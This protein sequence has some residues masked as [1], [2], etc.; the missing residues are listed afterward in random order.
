MFFLK[1]SKSVAI[2]AT[3]LAIGAGAYGLA[4]ATVRAASGTAATLPI[5]ALSGHRLSR[6][7]GSNARSGPAAGGSVGRVSSVSESGFELLTSAGE[8]VTIKETPSTTYEKD[9]HAAS[10]NAVTKDKTALVLGVANGTTITAM[11]VILEPANIGSGAASKVIP[12]RRGAPSTSKQLGK[13]PANYKQGSGT[14]VSGTKAN[15]ATKATLTDYPGGIVDRVVRISNGEYEVHNIG[16]S[17]PH[18]VFV[19]WNFKVVGAD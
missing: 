3:A 1:P 18:H 12:F 5:S 9:A 2:G 7:G 17:W 13:I 15:R 14:I 11:Q 6:S 10:A 4:G 8:K 16:V 19:S